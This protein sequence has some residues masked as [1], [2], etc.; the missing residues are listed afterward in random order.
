[1][2]YTVVIMLIKRD[3]FCADA[4]DPFY[5]NR[6]NVVKDCLVI[7]FSVFVHNVNAFR[8]LHRRHI[9]CI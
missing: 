2:W 8:T 5:D 7:F 4:I 6:S 9:S 3:Y 1:M